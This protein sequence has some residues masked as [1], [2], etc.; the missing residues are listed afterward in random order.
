MK[1]LKKPKA[2]FILPRMPRYGAVE[3][4][5]NYHKFFIRSLSAACILHIM[6]FSIFLIAGSSKREDPVVGEIKI[7]KYYQSGSTDSADGL[8][9]DSF[10]MMPVAARPGTN[11]KSI[12]T[13]TNQPF[14]QIDIPRCNQSLDWD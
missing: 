10:K 12:G 14:F 11:G 5:R 6:I 7:M 3:L 4:K 9:I 8:T 2:T 13:G 1:F